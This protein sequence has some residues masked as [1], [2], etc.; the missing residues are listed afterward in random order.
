MKFTDRFE[1]ETKSTEQLT[2]E[3][4]RNLKYDGDKFNIII[5]LYEN[6]IDKLGEIF[7]KLV[8]D[9]KINCGY[10]YLNNIHASS[11]I[12]NPNI[13]TDLITDVTEK[14][15]MSIRD[16]IFDG[17]NILGT[18]TFAMYI[19]LWKSYK[20]FTFKMLNFI[21]IYQK[22]TVKLGKKSYDDKNDD[23]NDTSGV[24]LL[25]STIK[26]FYD[27]ILNT[28]DSNNILLKISK[29]LGDI[30]KK[31]IDQL[32]YFIDSIRKFISIKEMIRIDSSTYYKI[33]QNIMSN[34]NNVNIMCS[35]IHDLLKN[36]YNRPL[37]DDIEYET[38]VLNDIDDKTVAKIYKMIGI[39]ATYVETDI[40]FLHYNKF[41]QIRIIDLKYGNLHLEIEIIKRMSNRLGINNS[42]KL[43]NMITD[44]MNTKKFNDI[45]HKTDINIVS[46]EY[47]QITDL[48]TKKLNPIILNKCIWDIYN[49]SDIEPFYPPEL[50]CYFDII[51]KIYCTV[52]DNKYGI[53]WQPTMGSARFEALL[54]TKQVD[55]TCNILQAIVLIYF[56]NNSK[57]T[58]KNFANETLINSKLADKIFDSLFEANI[59]IYL[60]SADDP[61]YMVNTRNYTGDN[62]ID[63]RY[64]FIKVFET[65]N[66]PDFKTS[67]QKFVNKPDLKSPYQKIVNKRD[68][69]P[70]YKK[71]INKKIKK[72]IKKL[73]KG[74]NKFKK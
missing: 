51:S 13:I 38:T 58:S 9:E 23:K 40:L 4:I 12:I 17:N 26:T 33:I 62:I 52:H 63:I 57:T 44:I 24:K 35:H 43:I 34:V 21:K 16:T 47:S 37:N 71:F 61:I 3:T 36:A 54:G 70:L 56:N 53:N 32:I 60:N 45:I 20:D 59:I 65:E 48:S 30:N 25:N 10:Y 22:P 39:L 55:I 42:Q 11:Q 69:K 8:T 50:K 28:S 6:P 73:V 64:T 66:K 27:E 2:S 7:N 67:Y 18:V 41:M 14:K 72:P 74:K 31:N 15:V 46:K 5:K 49:I 19:Q 68:L 29:D 1:L